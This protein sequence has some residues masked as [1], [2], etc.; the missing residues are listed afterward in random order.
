MA[1]LQKASSCLFSGAL[2]FSSRPLCIPTTE[3]EVGRISPIVPSCVSLSTHRLSHRLPLCQ[4]MAWASCV[5][6][7]HGLCRNFSSSSSITLLD[8]AYLSPL[9]VN[10]YFLLTHHNHTVDLLRGLHKSSY[11]LAYSSKQ[12]TLHRPSQRIPTGLYLFIPWQF[13]EGYPWHMEN[14]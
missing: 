14:I 1:F 10:S 7:L 6:Y 5:C 4:P 8:D 13:Q 3:Q 12:I 2:D 11:P 9:N